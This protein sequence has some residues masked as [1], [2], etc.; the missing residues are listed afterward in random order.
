MS[1]LTLDIP[2]TAKGDMPSLQLVQIIDQQ[3]RQIVALVAENA[4][5]SARVTALETP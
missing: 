2:V 1:K 4:A 5:L 3:Q